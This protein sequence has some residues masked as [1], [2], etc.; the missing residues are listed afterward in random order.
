MIYVTTVPRSIFLIHHAQVD[1]EIGR[2][3]V[4]PSIN[5]RTLS[6]MENVPGW[7]PDLKCGWWNLRVKPSYFAFWKEARSLASPEKKTMW[8]LGWTYH[9]QIETF[10]QLL[11]LEGNEVCQGKSRGNPH[12]PRV[13][14][15]S[16]LSQCEK[17]S[18]D[19]QIFEETSSKEKD[20]RISDFRGKRDFKTNNQYTLKEIYKTRIAYY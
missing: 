19:Q 8:S 1:R 18:K 4:Y 15:I 3:S 17:R 13:L 20:Q 5:Q 11:H 7:I 12:Q 2:C 6:N 9:P 10:R 16:V 14:H